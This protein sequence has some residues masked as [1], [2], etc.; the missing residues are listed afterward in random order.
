MIMHVIEADG[1]PNITPQF[2]GQHWVDTVAKLNYISVGTSSVTDWVQTASGNAAN[3]DLSVDAT[4][5]TTSTSYVLLDNM[6]ITPVAG[7]YLAVHTNT[8]VNSGNGAA[9]NFF[10]LFVNGVLV[11]GTER[12]IGI[13]GGSQSAASISKIIQVDGSQ[14]VEIRWRVVAGTG[15]AYNRNLSLVRLG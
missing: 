14:P 4:A 5:S 12:G 1:A 11:T 13:A 6:I 7:T 3:Y 15:T 2:V 10:G 9:R 8:S